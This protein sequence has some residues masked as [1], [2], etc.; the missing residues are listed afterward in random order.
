[1]IILTQ[2]SLIDNTQHA[3]ET[4]NHAPSEIQTRRSSKTVATHP[5]L[6]L[7]GLWDQFGGLLAVPSLILTLQTLLLSNFLHCNIGIACL[8]N[9]KMEFAKNP[10]EMLQFDLQS[11]TFSFVVVYLTKISV[12]GTI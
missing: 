1:V 6:R 4:D 3:Q 12:S 5:H 9:K 10:R 2:E 8:E 7:R 11:W